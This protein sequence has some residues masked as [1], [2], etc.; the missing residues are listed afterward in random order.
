VGKRRKQL[1]PVRV[2][3]LLEK[4]TTDFLVKGVL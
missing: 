4:N 1:W 3:K 2:M